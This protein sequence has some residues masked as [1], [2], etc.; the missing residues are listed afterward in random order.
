MLATILA[1]GLSLPWSR[2]SAPCPPTYFVV[3]PDTGH[4]SRNIGF[5]Q[6]LHAFLGDSRAMYLHGDRPL[7]GQVI[8]LISVQAQPP[9]D[10]GGGQR[11][12]V[13]CRRWSCPEKAAVIV[14]AREILAIGILNYRADSN[15]GLDVIVRRADSAASARAEVLR[16]WATAAV[17]DDSD[18]MHS[19][20]VLKGIKIRAL[21]YEPPPGDL[22]R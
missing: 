7:Y 18:R 16:Q 13:G 22:G 8:Q 3:C 5:Q 1:F 10:L 12:F 15:P 21:D 11:L 20:M 14:D 17:A 4:L 19:H 2:P 9:R 6:S